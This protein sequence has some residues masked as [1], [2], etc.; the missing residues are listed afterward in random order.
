MDED[1]KEA[2]ASYLKLCRLSASDFFTN[3]VKEVGLKNPLE[4]VA[5]KM[6]LRKWKRNFSYSLILGVGSGGAV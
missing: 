2:W 6:W 1:Y 3:M 5:W 4:D